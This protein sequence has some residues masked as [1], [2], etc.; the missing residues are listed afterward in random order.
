MEL[1]VSSIV[2]QALPLLWLEGKVTESG[3]EWSE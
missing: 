2:R 1:L 3:R